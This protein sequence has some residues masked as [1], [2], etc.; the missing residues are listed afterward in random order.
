MQMVWQTEH[1]AVTLPNE[2]VEAEGKPIQ[3][4]VTGQYFVLGDS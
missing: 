2:E 3:M 4:P 1:G